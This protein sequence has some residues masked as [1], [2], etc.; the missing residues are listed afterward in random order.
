MQRDSPLEKIAIFY[1]EQLSL[2]PIELLN[3]YGIV[4][5]GKDTGATQFIL[6]NMTDLFVNNIKYNTPILTRPINADPPSTL[7]FAN[8][9]T[10]GDSIKI[11]TPREL[12]ETFQ[13]LITDN[14]SLPELW[15]LVIA[16]IS[17]SR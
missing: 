9:T 1:E 4:V 16:Q 6:I 14:Y 15:E 5:P 2:E 11:Y 8:P 12:I 10:I 7:Y 13:L 3:K 17:Q